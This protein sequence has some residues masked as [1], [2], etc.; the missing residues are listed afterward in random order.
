MIAGAPSRMARDSTETALS[1]KSRL[2]QTTVAMHAACQ[3][4]QGYRAS[5]YMDE[6]Y[7]VATICKVWIP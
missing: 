5:W 6:G 1:A 2:L 3:L 4:E 7:P